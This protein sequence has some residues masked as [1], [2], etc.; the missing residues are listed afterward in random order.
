MKFDDMKMKKNDGV[1]DDVMKTLLEDIA[2]DVQFTDYITGM[3]IGALFCSLSDVQRL[4]V[5]CACIET[6]AKRRGITSFEYLDEI[7]QTIKEV[8]GDEEKRAP[9]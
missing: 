3:K 2:E 7:R 1:V 8:R 9:Q 6:A 4:P 5:L